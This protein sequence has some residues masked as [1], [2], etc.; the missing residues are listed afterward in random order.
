MATSHHGQAAGSEP[1]SDTIRRMLDQLEGT[2]RR[3]YPRGRMGALDDGALSYAVAADKEAGSVVI[4]FGKPV[5]WIGLAPGDVAK[6]VEV[7]VAKARE[8]ESGES[9]HI[10][11][12]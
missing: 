3:E 1:E 8:I 10:P 5:E 12:G 7:L 6:L 9:L 4:R 2:A 11:F